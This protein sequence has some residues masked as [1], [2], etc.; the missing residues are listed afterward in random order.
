MGHKMWPIVSSETVVLLALPLLFFLTVIVAII[1]WLIV[2]THVFPCLSFL[3]L[4]SLC[5]RFTSFP[6]WFHTKHIWDFPDN[7]YQCSTI[8]A[9]CVAG[10]CFSVVSQVNV[11]MSVNYKFKKTGNIIYYVSPSSATDMWCVKIASVTDFGNDVDEFAA[12]VSS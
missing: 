9:S 10:L 11:N 1:I 12:A 4:T 6:S 7:S 3:M 5:E 8:T 2:V